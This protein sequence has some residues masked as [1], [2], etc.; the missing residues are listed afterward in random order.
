M[1]HQERHTVDKQYQWGYCGKRLILEQINLNTLEM[2]YW[3][4][5][6]IIVIT[7]TKALHMEVIR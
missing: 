1:K 3:G 6:H 7:V 5:K 2:T 4:K